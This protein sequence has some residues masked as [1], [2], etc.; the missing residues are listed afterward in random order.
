[1]PS[2][3]GIHTDL[4]LRDMLYHDLG[5]VR[6]LWHHLNELTPRQMTPQE[7][8][9]RD[10]LLPAIQAVE[11]QLQGLLDLNATRKIVKWT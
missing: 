3:I 5:A 11:E 9:R 6:Q 2:P 8:E 7:K 1:M 4:R 10:E